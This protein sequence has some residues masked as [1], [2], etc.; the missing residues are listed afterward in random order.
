MSTASHVGL[1]KSVHELKMALEPPLHKFMV[2]PQPSHQTLQTQE[3]ILGTKYSVHQALVAQQNLY[4]LKSTATNKQK[5]ATKLDLE[6]ELQ[7]LN[8]R[9][10]NSVERLE[11]TGATQ[12]GG[13]D[14]ARRLASSN[15][16]PIRVV[17]FK[18]HTSSQPLRPQNSVSER[19][20]NQLFQRLLKQNEEQKNSTITRTK[21]PAPSSDQFA[22]KLPTEVQ[23]QAHMRNMIAL[24]R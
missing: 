10:A 12:E 3:N 16:N 22:A 18:K 1:T 15:K 7:V 19:P 13:S 17:P 20:P 9:K 4:G 11:Q 2:N 8:V 6:S 5:S 21:A 23:L 24:L 14:F